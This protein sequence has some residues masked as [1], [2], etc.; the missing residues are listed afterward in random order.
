MWTTP[1]LAAARRSCRLRRSAAP[2]SRKAPRALF[3]CTTVL[4]TI[5]LALLQYLSVT[6]LPGWF[7]M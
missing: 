6:G 1:T 3:L 5:A 4:T 2:C 7:V